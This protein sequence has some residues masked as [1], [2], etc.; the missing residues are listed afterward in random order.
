MLTRPST[1]L[2]DPAKHAAQAEAFFQRTGE[3]HTQF[4]YLGEWHSHPRFAALPSDKD[5]SSMRLLLADPA[6]GVNFVVLLI[7]RRGG[8]GLQVSATIYSAG[9]GS[10]AVRIYV[11]YTK[12]LQWRKRVRQL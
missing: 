1:F 12:A 9:N 3:N 5:A 11:E 4:N 10:H 6:V 8:S 2:R 7:V